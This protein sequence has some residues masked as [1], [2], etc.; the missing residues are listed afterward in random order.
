MLT[1]WNLENLKGIILNVGET[2]EIE[3]ENEFKDK[4][5]IKILI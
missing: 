2:V 5:D 1:E 4:A 3:G